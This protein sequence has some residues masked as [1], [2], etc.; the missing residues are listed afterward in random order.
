VHANAILWKVV[1]H[2][3]RALT[4]TTKLS[5]AGLNVNP[6]EI[7]DLMDHLWNVGVLLQTDDALNV[8]RP[9]RT[10]VRTTVYYVVQL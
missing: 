3:L 2:E 7:N 9:V 4:N 1:F 6:M 8:L 10:P 5:D